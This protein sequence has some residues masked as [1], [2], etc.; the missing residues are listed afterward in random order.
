M[1]ID[2]F[3]PR[4]FIAMSGPNVG[5][6][7]DVFEAFKVLQTHPNVD[8]DRVSVM[9]WSWGGGIALSSAA[10]TKERTNGHVLQSMVSFYPVCGVSAIPFTGNK[11]AEILLV[12]GTEDTYSKD[13]QCKEVVD[14]GVRDGRKA[15][16][17]VYK[18]AYH[19]FDNDKDITFTHG[20]FGEQTIK[21]DGWITRQA[22][23]DVLAFLKAVGT[24]Q[25]ISANVG[26]GSGASG[27]RKPEGCKDPTFASLFP[28][29]CS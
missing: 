28:N 1:V 3:G 5:G 29:I 23:K 18:G 21:A 16:L 24:S 13:W 25:G 7:D 22:Q 14:K 9:G 2:M 17:I 26:S 27:N 10:T 15:R 4:N 11:D 6:Y 19:G 12:I 8:P 20:K